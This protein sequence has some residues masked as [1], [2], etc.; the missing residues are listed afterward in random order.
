MAGAYRLALSRATVEVLSPEGETIAT[1]TGVT[2]TFRDGTAVA[3]LGSG[4]VAEMPA[5]DVTRTGRNR[6]TIAGEDGT[7]WLVSKPCGCAGGR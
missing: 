3:R 5:T 1:H 7:T 4:P 6:Y 2:A